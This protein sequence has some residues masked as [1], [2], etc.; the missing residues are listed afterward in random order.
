MLFIG[1][2]ISSEI[3]STYVNASSEI[4]PRSIFKC[5]IYSTPAYAY[6]YQA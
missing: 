4:I 2:I 1:P 6:I 3:Y 5:A